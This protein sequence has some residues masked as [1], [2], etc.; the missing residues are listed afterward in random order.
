MSDKETRRKCESGLVVYLS[1]PPQRKCKNCGQMWYEGTETPECTVSPIEKPI[2]KLGH[3]SE[4]DWCCACE[5]DIAVMESTIQNSLSSLI[6][7]IKKMR[8]EDPNISIDSVIAKI[9]EKLDK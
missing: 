4:P 9:K 1:M 6:S 5:Y 2:E 3:R 8:K 7:E